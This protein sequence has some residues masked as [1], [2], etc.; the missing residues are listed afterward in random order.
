MHFSEIFKRET[1]MVF[2]W[3]LDGLDRLSSGFAS[4]IL[5]C[6]TFNSNRAAAKEMKG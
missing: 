4:S 3:Q 6:L 1:T 5:A 2:E